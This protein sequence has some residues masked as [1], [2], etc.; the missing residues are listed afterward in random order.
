MA[1]SI[2]EVA[3]CFWRRH[4][5]NHRSAISAFVGLQAAVSGV[6]QIDQAYVQPHELHFHQAGLCKVCCGVRDA[7]TNVIVLDT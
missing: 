1:M 3:F 5:A 7:I 4:D 6:R 2:F